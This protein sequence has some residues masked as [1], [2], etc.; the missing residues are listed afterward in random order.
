MLAQ[1]VEQRTFNPLVTGSNP[2]RPTKQGKTMNAVGMMSGPIVL[3]P[4]YGKAYKTSQEAVEAWKNGQDFKI[5]GGSYCSIRDMDYLVDHCS[6]I[7]IDWNRIDSVRV[8]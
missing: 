8:Y 2:V 1:M 7:W 6:T 5:V 3:M 4:A